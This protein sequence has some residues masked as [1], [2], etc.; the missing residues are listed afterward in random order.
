MKAARGAALAELDFAL[1]QAEVLALTT[2]EQKELRFR[3]CIAMAERARGGGNSATAHSIHDALRVA[4]TPFGLLHNR[5][6][7]ERARSAGARAITA[8]RDHGP[9]RCSCWRYTREL[10]HDIRRTYGDRSPEGWAAIR[11]WEALEELESESRRE[12]NGDERLIV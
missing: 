8:C 1:K 12:S 6:W 11:L 2:D 7:I 4:E 3:T 5:D 9:P 10:L